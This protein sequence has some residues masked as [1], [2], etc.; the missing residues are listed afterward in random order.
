MTDSPLRYMRVSTLEDSTFGVDKT[1]LQVFVVA[2]GS[3]Q[4]SFHDMLPD[5]DDDFSAR[6]DRDWASH[7]VRCHQCAVWEHYYHWDWVP[8]RFELG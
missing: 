4:D 8:T 2:S 3:L 6:E 5:A 1:Q 7:A